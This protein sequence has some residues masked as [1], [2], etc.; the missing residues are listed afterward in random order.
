MSPDPNL[1]D[2]LP[3]FPLGT[4]LLPGEHLPL[5]V[6]E[7]R[8]REMLDVCR[9]APQGPLFGVVLIERGHEVGGGEVRH[10][11]GTVAQILTEHQVEPTVFTLDCLGG[12]RI[13]VLEW[14]PD[15]P[16]PRARVQVWPEPQDRVALDP[17]VERY[18]ELH[19]LAADLGA[20][21]PAPGSV[22]GDLPALARCVP[23]GPADRYAVLAARTSAQRRG[24]IGEAVENAIDMV[25]WRLREQ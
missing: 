5:R 19:R 4:V 21:L 6:F 3:M 23:M 10:D 25:R 11:V 20:H 1:P 9:A 24:L 22:D 17:L 14:L 13:R 8:Y 2:V 7:P 15:D 18:R 16:F 12:Q